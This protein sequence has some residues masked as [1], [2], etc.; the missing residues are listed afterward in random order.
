MV[1]P[2]KQLAADHAKNAASLAR[3]FRD[4]AFKAN[5]VDLAVGV[6]IGAAFTG[7]INSLVKNVLMPLI[8]LLIPNDVAYTK[9]SFSVG[10]KTV[11]YGEFLG[12]LVNFLIVALVLYIFTVKFLGWLRRMRREQEAAAP[13]LT[14][15]QQLLTEIRDLLRENRPPAPTP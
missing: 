5:I 14:K 4:F 11:P 10:G 3:E 13:V 15:E 9:W 8:S 7:L 2:L 1:D 12:E 6:I